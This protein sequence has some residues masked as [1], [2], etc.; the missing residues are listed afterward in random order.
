MNTVFVYGTLKQGFGNHR[1][2]ERATLVGAAV[3]P[4]HSYT[5]VSLGVFPAVYLRGNNQ[6]CG[7]LYTDV[8]RVIMQHLDW[9]EGYP[10]FYNRSIIKVKTEHDDTLY[11]AWMYHFDGEPVDTGPVIATGHWSK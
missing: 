4:T 8:D 6:I 9:L 2:L 11:D 7:E 5:M 3:T 1:L 10:D